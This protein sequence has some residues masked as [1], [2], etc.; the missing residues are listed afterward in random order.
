[1]LPGVIQQRGV[2]QQDLRRLALA[3]ALTILG[4]VAQHSDG[5]LG[6]QEDPVFLQR[7]AFRCWRGGIDEAHEGG[8]EG[9]GVGWLH[10]GSPLY[11]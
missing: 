11:R 2:R 9:I 7:S 8:D 4:I 1:M 3:R 6:Q 5:L 10:G